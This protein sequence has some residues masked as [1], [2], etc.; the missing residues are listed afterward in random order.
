MQY[1]V[2]PEFDE[3]FCR[4]FNVLPVSSSEDVP[5]VLVSEH[6]DLAI[7]GYIEYRLARRVNPISISKSEIQRAMEQLFASDDSERQ[8]RIIE[9]VAVI[10]QGVVSHLDD[11]ITSCLIDGASDIHMEATE[12]AVICRARIDGILVKRTFGATDN[13]AAVISRLKIMC[14]LDIAEKR[15]PQDGRIRF[16]FEGRQIDIRVSIIPTEFG[17]KAV[18]RLLDK[19]QLRL[20]LNLLGFSGEQLQLF[21]EKINLSNG[22][23]LVTG[24]TGS[25]KTTT[26]YAALN[27]LQ[28]STLNISTIEDPIEYQLSGIN[29]T[30]VKPA[31]NLTF[32]SMLRSLLRQ[33]PN[34]IMVGEIRDHET[35]EIAIR[36]SLTGH[37]VFSTVHTN[38][39]IATITRLLD[40]GA[41]PYMLS[42]SLR[43]IVAQR[44]VRRNCPHC[45]TTD[46][47]DMHQAA[48]AKLGIQ[49]NP[50]A[51]A[52]SGCKGCNMTG[53]KGRLGIFELLSIDSDIKNAIAQKASEVELEAI[54]KKQG[55][56][57]MQETA[58]GII[59]SGLTSPSEVLREMSI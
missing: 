48:A 49:L 29:Q 53:Y 50:E 47:S 37:L 22:I 43:L 44:L 5:Q 15:R 1:T 13:P 24:P 8:S 25:G 9:P 32:A 33:D 57:A 10:E 6:S 11:L 52:G 55:F 2:R 38:S 56:Y 20:D 40:M 39:A 42:S 45:S 12:G 23:I 21:R 35:L 58:K 27:S 26:L 59:D 31:I 30:Q 41:E 7:I 14:G 34:V 28:S 36:A 3:T 19:K 18:L 46:L 4:S 17:E 16:E 54:A 51:K